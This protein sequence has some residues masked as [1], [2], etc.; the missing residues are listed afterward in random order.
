MFEEFRPYYQLNKPK[1]TRWVIP[2]IHGCYGTLLAILNKIELTKEDH[3]FFLGDFIDRG[4]L[5]AAVLDHLFNLHDLGFQIFPLRGNHEEMLLDA[6]KLDPRNVVLQYLEYN[7]TKDLLNSER[8]IDS[9]YISFMERLPFYYEL[10]DFFL[11][12]AGFN[13]NVK[14]PLASYEEMI[15]IRNFT[16]NEKIL[17]G[18]RM[19]YGHT[20]T[21][22]SVIKK[23]ISNKNTAIP[24][25]NG[26]VFYENSLALPGYEIG[27]LLCFNLD[28]Q[29]LI[30]QPYD[31]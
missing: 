26:C 20:P 8:E 1:G 15:W 14:N 7:N 18:K 29:E 25:D 31:D 4:P 28:T 30:V 21:G 3:L 2:D 10:E 9:K 6:A 19:I 23:A 16:P 5:S 13:F 22:L 24:L 12:H 27:N 17:R 11:V